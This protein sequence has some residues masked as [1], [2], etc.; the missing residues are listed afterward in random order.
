MSATT[1]G[2]RHDPTAYEIRVGGHLDPRWAA[3]F[4][5]LSLAV[6]SD[7]TTVLHGLVLDQSALFGLLQRIRDA[8]LALVSVNQV[9]LDLTE[10]RTTEAR[11]TDVR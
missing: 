8:G 2:T 11:T 3:W 9:D 7:G 5:G 1:T 10:A 4:D 6:A